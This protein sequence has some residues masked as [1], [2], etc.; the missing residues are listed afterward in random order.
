MF[1]KNWFRFVVLALALVVMV[2]CQPVQAASVSNAPVE[3]VQMETQTETMSFEVAEDGTRFVFSQERLFEDGMP[4]Y[5]TPFV[6]QGYLYPVGTLNGSN[7]ALADGSAEFPDKVIGEWTCYG[8]MIGDGGHTESGKWVVS[9]QI[10]QFNEEYDNAI[11]ITDGF[12][13]AD[14][15]VPIART[16]TGGTGQFLGAVGEQVQTLL[17]FTEQMGV[18]LTVELN[19]Q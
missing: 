1:T 15:N 5:G 12:E 16:I 10:Y 2:A 13:V 4:Q 6:T 14:L 18:N 11:V 7:G 8:W 17:G 3:S 9:T 19:I